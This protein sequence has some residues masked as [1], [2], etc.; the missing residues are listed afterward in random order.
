VHG[1]EVIIAV[2]RAEVT[3]RHNFV[4]PSRTRLLSQVVS[5]S[6]GTAALRQP[7]GGRFGAN[8][9]L[10]EPVGEPTLG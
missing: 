6:T 10:A 7:E 2:T 4:I 3:P 9:A 5:G 8:A 1:H